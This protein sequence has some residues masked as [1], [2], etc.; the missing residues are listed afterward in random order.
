[1]TKNN[2]PEIKKSG[3]LLEKTQ[4]GFENEGVFNPGSYQDGETIHLLYRAVSEGNYSTVGYCRLSDPLTIAERAETPVYRPSHPSEAHGVEDPR[5]VKI[6]GI[7]Y[8]AYVAYDGINAAGSLA[9]STDLKHFSRAGF[10]TPRITMHDF[11]ELAEKYGAIPKGYYYNVMIPADP[12]QRKSRLLWDK[13]VIFFPRKING[14]LA[15]LHRVFPGIQVVYC[16]TPEDL[17]D[18]FWEDY[19]GN[20]RSHIVLESK[21]SFERQ[22]IGGGCVPVETPEGWLLIYHG[23]EQSRAGKV[24]HAAAALLDINDPTREIARLSVPLFSPEKEWEVTGCVNNVVFPTGTAQIGDQLYIYYG[25]GDSKIGVASLS[26]SGLMK[27]L[28]KNKSIK[29]CQ[30]SQDQQSIF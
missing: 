15:F 19:F 10:L 6:D 4:L 14:R 18:A 8:M 3:I 2:S 13:D 21:H 16:D 27:A 30:V 1:M 5:V 29:S 23:V 26:L 28:L 24:Y 7:Y 11:R 9:V 22:Y 17:T 25:A 12:E 20:F